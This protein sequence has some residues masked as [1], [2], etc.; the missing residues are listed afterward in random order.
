VKRTLTGYGGPFSVSP[1]GKLLVAGSGTAYRA[2]GVTL[3]ELPAGRLLRKLPLARPEFSLALSQDGR[4]L[5][6]A[7][8]GPGKA[9]I[10]GPWSLQPCVVRLWETRTGRLLRVLSRHNEPV[11]TL[12]FSPD[13]RTLVSGGGAGMSYE[14]GKGIP[15]G[16]L[17]FWDVRTGWL[18]RKISGWSEA[19]YSQDGRLLALGN[20]A[21]R[22]QLWEVRNPSGQWKLRRTM[23]GG[24]GFGVV[25][26]FSPDGK[27]LA[28]GS[29]SESGGSVVL[30]DTRTGNR[31]HRLFCT[32]PGSITFS[33]DGRTVAAGGGHLDSHITLWDVRTGAEIRT[34]AG[35]VIGLN[36]LA[37][38]PDGRML[39][40]AYGCERVGGWLALW[41]TRSGALRRVVRS[42]SLFSIAFSPDG[43]T[44][45]GG[46]NNGDVGGGVYL[47]EVQA[48]A[49]GPVNALR[50]SAAQRTL[51]DDS[52]RVMK[53]LFHPDG[54]TVLSGD[55]R[56][57]MSDYPD[58]I[59][60]VRLWDSGTGKLQRAIKGLRLG[61]LSPDGKI[62][63]MDGPR[64]SV[65]LWDVGSGKVV[66][67]LRG[68]KDR[69]TSA[70]FSPDGRTLA[71]GS[72]DGTI[73]FWDA[74]TGA[75]RRA[76][77][78]G[79]R[80]EV[81]QLGFS[82]ADA[83]GISTL[84][85]VSDA[86]K[87]RDRMT[88]RL[89]QTLAEPGRV[90]AFAFSPD[91]RTLATCGSGHSAKLWDL[92]SGRLLCTLAVL[93]VPDTNEPPP[94]WIAFTPGGHYLASPGAGKFIRWRVGEQLFPAGRFEPAYHR[95]ELVQR[96]LR[97]SR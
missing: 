57:D 78:D 67:R 48:L 56:I 7:D 50:E 29:G 74:R 14:D 58:G 9:D 21:A 66:R 68:H 64:N 41:D 80:G 22:V 26:A 83:R 37:F 1:D 39:A 60:E 32:W 59:D 10:M 73:R 96:V 19:A 20:E 23:K 34:L 12:A 77:R 92:R 84:V 55:D 69:I 93:P 62:A 54:K 63:A 4:L 47:W 76:V 35:E 25:L 82:P 72:A 44:L 51:C 16:E 45:A 52:E 81:T 75:P 61:A 33:P 2:G 70:A 85:G 71:S 97:S 42:N 13:G 17:R 91:G 5:A 30:W 79:C 90:R 94:E 38:S 95:P 6:T 3:H 15:T 53:V 31:L 88:G 28:G 87:L 65:D 18:K 86:V 43:K 11:T 24:E 36:A 46:G 89:R 27:V 40:S 8:A 49:A